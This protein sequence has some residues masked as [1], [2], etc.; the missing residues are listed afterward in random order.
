MLKHF[1][2]LAVHLEILFSRHTFYAVWRKH[3]A[4]N[5]QALIYGHARTHVCALCL[6][7][8]PQCA[9]MVMKQATEATTLLILSLNV[10]LNLNYVVIWGA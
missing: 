3:G 6:N 9:D 5:K 8:L 7:S 10:P 4:T 2:N 1:L